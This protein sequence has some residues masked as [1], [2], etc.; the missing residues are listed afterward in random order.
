MSKKTKK[1]KDTK[2]KHGGHMAN[3]SA[4]WGKNYKES[5][6]KAIAKA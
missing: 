6:T 5:I 2:L 3:K 4:S 1:I